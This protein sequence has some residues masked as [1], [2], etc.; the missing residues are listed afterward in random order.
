M[1]ASA[2]VAALHYLALA[3][4]LPAVFLR[5]R[6]LRGPLDEAGLR[7]L[8]AADTAWGLAAALWV[9]TGLWRAFG[10]LEKGAA[11]YLAS[12]L[13]Y[14][15]MALFLAI[16]ALEAWPMVTFIR[17]RRARRRGARVDARRAP[18][19]YR[20]NHVQLA[21]AV[22]MVFVASAMARGLW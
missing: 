15:K 19:L 7:R 20:V 4:G 14:L 8:L 1:W 18:A 10:G 3:V 16:V 22:L 2:L 11:F 17:W 9:A 12:R 13:F 6:A 5:G 21:L